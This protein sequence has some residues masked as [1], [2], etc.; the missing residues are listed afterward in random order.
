MKREDRQPRLPLIAARV[1]GLW[2]NKCAADEAKV[3]DARE[4]K[5]LVPRVF[6]TVS[7][8]IYRFSQ[9]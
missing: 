9:G 2:P 7:I 4:K 5:L 1:F 6:V 3:P 8:V